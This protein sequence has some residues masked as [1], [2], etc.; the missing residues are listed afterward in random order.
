M[1]TTPGYLIYC[2][3]SSEA[4]DRQVLSI[5]SQ[6]AEMRRLAES[7]GLAVLEVLT[8]ARSAKAP[9]RP[10]FNAM[11]Q[12]VYRGELQGVICWKL[13]RLAR[14]PIDGG[15]VIWAMKQHALEIITPVQAFRQSDDNTILMYIEFGMAQKYIDDLSRNVKR[16]L[17]TKIEKG[18]LPAA[19]PIGYVNKPVGD[20]NI[21]ADDPDRFPAI[22]RMWDLM[23][24]GRY[25][26]PQILR[27]TNEEWGFRTRQRRK[28]G[29]RPLA[30]SAIY[31]MFTDPFYYGWFEFPRGSGQLWK[32]NH[33]PMIS[34][35]EFDRVQVLLGRKGKPRPFK[36]E[37]PFVGLIRCGECGAMVTAEE[38][39]HVVCS[40]CR[41]KFA[42][43]HR[44]RCPRCLLATDQ[45]VDPIR[46]H[47]VYYHCTRRKKPGCHQRAVEGHLLERQIETNLM[48][49]RI[50]DEF[51]RLGIEYA[52]R[53][54]GESTASI[55][56]V[57][58]ERRRALEGCT[59]R[60]EGL[61]RLHTSP[62][63]F[64]ASLLSDD[65]YRDQRSRLLREQAKLR[66]E[67]AGLGG[68][69]EVEQ[70]VGVFEFTH[71]VVDVFARGDVAT[72]RRIL[73]TVGSNLILQDKALRFHAAAPF[74]LL[75]TDD[76]RMD[77][78][79]PRFEPGNCA[80]VE[81]KTTD[82]S[83]PLPSRRGFREDVRTFSGRMEFIVRQIHAFLDDPP[84]NLDLALI[85]G[86]HD[87]AENR[88]QPN[89][90]MP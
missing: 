15:A 80:V 57:A 36:R 7:R 25:S 58:A 71:R 83:G 77:A 88:P 13:D 49:I 21:I 6:I 4:E 73:S 20:L 16:G 34:E 26:P 60:L 54:H 17:R 85:S 69:H 53:L 10:V 28:R 3:K 78:K 18:W 74:S 39:H 38:K 79:E 23:L 5:D 42:A 44:L 62:G 40:G 29:G 47:Y 82:S 2:R 12:R 59:R 30:Q 81:R 56:A 46:R 35:E 11:M 43:A 14:N 52:R 1:P 75:A 65:E 68:R 55:R 87:G 48:A 67:L 70:C 76:S 89:D 33:P 84:P 51:R 22:R 72:R 27:I 41:Y 19:A 64:D 37:F 63:N 90:V 9:G 31:R 66:T 8:E 50:S 32:G 45:M 86:A 24:S 61:I